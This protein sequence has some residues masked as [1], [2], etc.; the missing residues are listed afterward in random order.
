MLVISSC[1]LNFFEV[2][3]YSEFK[4]EIQ[5]I[6]CFIHLMNGY[7]GLNSIQKFVF[8]LQR[9]TEHLSYRHKL[10]YWA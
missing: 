6:L 4:S 7:V 3:F 10:V 8:Y 2:L 1:S 9:N 5:E